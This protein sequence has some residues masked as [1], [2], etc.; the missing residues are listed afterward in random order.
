[1]SIE[2]EV[3]LELECPLCKDTY[4]EPKT[5]GCLHSFCL[6][7]LEIYAERNH[8]NVNLSCP[9]CRTPFQKQQLVDLPT[10]SFILN[11]LNT[12]NSLANS[13]FQK[14][15]QHVLCL[16]KENEA[17]YYCLE[18]QEYLCE[19]CSKT[20]QNAKITMKHQVIP[21]EEIKNHV[22]INS[23]P[24][25]NPHTYC[26]IHQHEELKLF[27]DDCKE[28]ICSLCVPKHPS[29]KILTLVD[30]IENEKQTLS[31]LINMVF[32]FFL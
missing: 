32:F 27:C 5:L 1:M 13:V 15:N 26:Q 28:P 6:E 21:I 9:I 30:V 19:I 31:D 10:D 14:D 11:A 22:Q 8:S 18:C 16:D 24:K 29:T 20:H 2:H 25:S 17:T 4:R 23:I 7:C 3:G 12:Y